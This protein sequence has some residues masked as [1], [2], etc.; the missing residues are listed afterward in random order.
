LANREEIVTKQ[1]VVLILL[2]ICFVFWPA[3]CG[4]QESK[5]PIHFEENYKCMASSDRQ[6]DYSN[7]KVVGIQYGDTLV[8][9]NCELIKLIGID[10]PKIELKTGAKN[11]PL[12]RVKW[13]NEIKSKTF[14]KELIEGKQVRLE[15][16]VERTDKHRRLMAYVFVDFLYLEGFDFAFQPATINF[17]GRNYL[18]LN[19]FII[20][21]GYASP[22]TMPPNIKHA[23]LFQKLYQEAWENNRG[24]WD[25]VRNE[26]RMKE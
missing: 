24:L 19:A 16:D 22:M 20:Q 2:L 10:C 23:D 17:D 7:I 13:K 15:F 6:Y 1:I 18:F 8:L 12:D 5:D 21:A 3:A 26:R 14:V 11:P 25:R 4:S 9:E